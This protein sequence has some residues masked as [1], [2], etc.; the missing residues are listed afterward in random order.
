MASHGKMSDGK[1]VQPVGLCERP[2]MKD[3][4]LLKGAIAELAFVAVIFILTLADGDMG[5]ILGLAVAVTFLAVVLIIWDLVEV[6]RK[7]DFRKPMVALILLDF[8]VLVSSS[9]LLYFWVL[10]DEGHIEDEHYS[11]YVGL[12]ALMLVCMIFIVTGRLVLRARDRRL[13]ESQQEELMPNTPMSSN[14]IHQGSNNQVQI[15]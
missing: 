10:L 5:V 15:V 7:H 8:V 4:W 3:I 9:V 1:P 12:D 6:L 2:T 11:T 13:E 14:P